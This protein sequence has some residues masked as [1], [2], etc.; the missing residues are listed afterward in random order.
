MSR[1]DLKL[2]TPWVTQVTEFSKFVSHCIEKRRLRIDPNIFPLN[3]K[4]GFTCSV[5]E[6]KVVSVPTFL[7]ASIRV[8]KSTNR[9][10]F[11][12]RPKNTKLK[13]SSSCS[14]HLWKLKQWG[15]SNLENF[16]LWRRT[17]E[18]ICM[19]WNKGSKILYIWYRQFNATP[20]GE[21]SWFKNS[22]Y[23]FG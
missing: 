12:P 7:S 5:V 14:I 13:F 15:K 4:K 23:R 20:N 19:N 2:Q 9:L 8:W 17:K 1:V 10:R 3:V 6:L 18:S 11:D 21:L 22:I 16:T